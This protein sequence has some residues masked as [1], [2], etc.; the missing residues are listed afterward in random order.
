MVLSAAER[1]KLEHEA[2]FLRATIAFFA[3]RLDVIER[4]L[5]K[6][7]A[8]LDDLDLNVRTYNLLKRKHS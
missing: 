6:Y 1:L 2:E 8:K 5:E 7:G 4:Q 3:R